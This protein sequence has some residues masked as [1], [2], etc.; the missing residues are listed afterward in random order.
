MNM[1]TIVDKITSGGIGQHSSPSKGGIQPG[2]GGLIE[3]PEHNDVLSGRGGRINNH[4]G[5]LYYRTL[6]N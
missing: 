5:N 3:F 6:V 1:H 2:S 4:P